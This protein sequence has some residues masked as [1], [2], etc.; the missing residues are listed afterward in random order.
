[1]ANICLFLFLS[2]HTRFSLIGPGNLPTAA[3]LS[4]PVCAIVTV[5]IYLSRSATRTESSGG[6]VAPAVTVRAAAGHHQTTGSSTAGW[7]RKTPA[8]KL[9]LRKSGSLLSY[10]QLDA[11]SYR[12]PVKSPSQYFQICY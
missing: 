6:A 3:P 2:P 4:N 10:S 8:F 7:P 9:H 1:M 12:S 11:P 5:Q